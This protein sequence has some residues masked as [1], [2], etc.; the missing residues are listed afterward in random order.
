MALR[1]GKN[2]KR[3]RKEQGDGDSLVKVAKV[4]S[5]LAF[6]VVIAA[7]LIVVFFIGARTAYN[8]GYDLFSGKTVDPAPGKDVTVVIGEDMTHAEFAALLHKKGLIEDENAAKIMLY[9]FT[10]KN[11]DL[12][13]GQYVLNTSMTTRQM[14]EKVSAEVEKEEPTAEHLG[15]YD[16]PEST[17][18]SPEG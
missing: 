7:V 3:S 5:S 4:T 17:Q 10:N 16:T 13:P 18:E 2:R 14:I 12:K 1:T 11:F 15:L 8:Y 9:I 6:R